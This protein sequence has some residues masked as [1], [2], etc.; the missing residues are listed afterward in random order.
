MIQEKKLSNIYNL[1]YDEIKQILYTCIDVLG[2]I[3]VEEAQQALGVGRQRVYQLMNENTTIKIG[4]HK[5]ICINLI[6]NNE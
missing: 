1:N 2:M 6:K 4:T 3:D 5:F